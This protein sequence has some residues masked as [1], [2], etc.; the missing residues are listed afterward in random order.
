MTLTS[1]D[2]KIQH[3]TSTYPSYSLDHFYKKFERVLRDGDYS[4]L[5]PLSVLESVFLRDFN[6]VLEAQDIIEQATG[7]KLLAQELSH[8][9]GGIS[10]ALGGFE[11]DIKG[12]LLKYIK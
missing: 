4:L 7:N 11:E 3:S 10:W 9:I 12:I 8:Y 1:Q 5:R 6:S 2:H